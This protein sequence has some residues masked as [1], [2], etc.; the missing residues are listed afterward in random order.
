MTKLAVAETTSGPRAALA[1]NHRLV[2]DLR[3]QAAEANEPN[4]R[5]QEL[6]DAETAAQAALDAVGEAEAAELR[7][8][9]DH[10]GAQPAPATA[11]REAALRR[12]E[13]ARRNAEVAR[14]AERERTERAERI[15]RLLGEAIKEQA[16][17]I[18]EIVL[19]EAG[20]EVLRRYRADYLAFMRS[21]ALTR[22][23]VMIAHKLGTPMTPDIFV[24]WPL[25][26]NVPAPSDALGVATEPF[27][28]TGMHKRAADAWEAFGESL[29]ADPAAQL[30]DHA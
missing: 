18:A 8:W 25:S 30:A 21:Y 4:P 2:A 24:G 23:L 29:A 1:E 13:A 17:V 14:T 20:P 7:R 27:D 6:L 22:G 26:I 5:L 12:L 10:V 16:R 15:G 9:L 11:K 19:T 28:L 3:R